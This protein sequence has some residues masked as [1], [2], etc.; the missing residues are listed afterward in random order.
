LSD[1]APPPLPC[2]W[3]GE[4]FVPANAHWLL[5][6]DKHFAVGEVYPLEVHEARS[7][8]S[9][10]HLFAVINEAWQNLPEAQA[11]RFASAEHLR[12]WALIRAGYYDERS[13]VCADEDEAQRIA[14]FVRPLDDYAIVVVRGC[15]VAV[16][17][18]KSQSA[19][20]M[21]RQDFQRSKDAVLDIIA[22]LIGTTTQALTQA[23]EA[24]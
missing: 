18:A 4:H 8:P 21:G 2:R 14:A 20:A 12:K 5:T 24:A 17:T 16:Y 15:V 19:R 3:D 6:A 23:G 9:H 10:R 1:R 22:G 13:I 11:R 7:D